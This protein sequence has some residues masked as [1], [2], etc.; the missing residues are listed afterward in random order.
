MGG[1]NFIDVLAVVL[2]EAVVGQGHGLLR[3]RQGALIV[4]PGQKDAAEC[5]PAVIIDRFDLD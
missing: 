1:I 2:L 4:F 3:R 5:V